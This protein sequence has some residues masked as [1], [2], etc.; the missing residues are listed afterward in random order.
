MNE[1]TDDDRCGGPAKL[2]RRHDRDAGEPAAVVTRTGV[3]ERDHA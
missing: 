3:G 2:F 1:R